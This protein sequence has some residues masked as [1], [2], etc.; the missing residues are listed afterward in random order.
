MTAGFLS[1]ALFFS[2]GFLV[3]ALMGALVLRS[4][5]A[6]HKVRLDHIEER[7]ASMEKK[8]DNVYTAAMR[9]LGQRHEQG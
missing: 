6:E 3:S 1:S 7:L 9:A 2:L 5:Q 8:F 4:Q